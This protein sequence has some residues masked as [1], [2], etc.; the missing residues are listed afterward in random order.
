MRYIHLLNQS[1]PFPRPIKVAYCSSFMSR[2]RG[3]MFQKDIDPGTGILLVENFESRVNTTIH[4]LFMNF[5]IATIWIDSN[6]KVVDTCYARRW[7]PYYAPN[8]PARYILET[9]PNHLG[10]FQVG[11][12]LEFLNA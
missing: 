7:R 8:A 5:D 1:H 12:C 11:D 9:H 10:D 6:K 3:L 4:M 2:F